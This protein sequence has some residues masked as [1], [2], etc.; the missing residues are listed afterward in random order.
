MERI[1]NIALDFILYRVLLEKNV[2]IENN[3]LN[4]SL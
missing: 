3:D 2:N 1:L 4:Y